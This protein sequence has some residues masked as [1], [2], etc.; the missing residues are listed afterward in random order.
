LI[1][2]R[3]ER[4]TIENADY[5]TKLVDQAVLRIRPFVYKTPLLYSAALSKKTGMELY[6]KME[7]WQKCGSFK[8]RG[9]ANFLSQLE[10][11]SR[12][13]LLVTASSGNHGLALA[14]MSRLMGKGSVCIYVPRKA[15]KAKIEKIKLLGAQIV[16]SGKDFF[17]SLDLAMASARQ[18]KGIYVHSHAHPHIIAGQGTI[19]V[20]ILED[21]PDTDLIVVPIG[22]GGLVA[23]IASAVKARIPSIRIL[24]VEPEAAPGAYL[25]L[26][27]GRSIERIQL[28]P[29][30]ADGLLGGFSPLPFSI[31]GNLIESV[32][33]VKEE[34]IKKAMRT[35]FTEEQLIVEGASAVGLAAILAGKIHEPK[36]KVVLVL[37]G[38]N[39]N[40]NNF[41]KVIQG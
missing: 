25:S 3:E 36:K 1:A 41:I 10:K 35:F 32:F 16:C 24:G 5:N 22:G 31:A 15:D 2:M 29:S 8:V 11:G 23:G 6:L 33:L 39:I 7:C 38:R 14:F 9:V 4:Y 20:E 26:R 34:E 12:D 21:L 19:G 18:K 40:A 37:T 27:E 28:H 17:A 13:L 30:L